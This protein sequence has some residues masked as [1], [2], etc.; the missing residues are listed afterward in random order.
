MTF[1]EELQEG[2]PS[3]LPS[4]PDLNPTVNRAPRRKEILSA[5]EKKLALRNALRYFPKEWHRE[6][7]NE[8]LDEL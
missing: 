6:L 8:F 1:Q 2:I 4:A 5:E 3:K 7:A